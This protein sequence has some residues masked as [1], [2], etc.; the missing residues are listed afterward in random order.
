MPSGFQFAR[1]D[2]VL[3]LAAAA[4][5]VNSGAISAPQEI[6]PLMFAAHV[7]AATGTTPTLDV[8]LEQSANG[9]SGWAAVPGSAL[10]QITAVGHRVGFAAPTQPYVRVVATIGGTTPAITGRIAVIVFAD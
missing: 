3:D 8:S 10:T 7:T 1:G 9:Q 2:V 6:G 4:T 5:S